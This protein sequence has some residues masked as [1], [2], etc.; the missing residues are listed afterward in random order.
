M[1]LGDFL[2]RQGL[3]TWL[4]GKTHFY[5]DLVGI[6]RLGIEPDSS[7]GKL[8]LQCGFQIFEHIEGLYPEG[9]KGRYN[10]LKSYYE[11]FLNE[12]GY[13]GQN[14]WNDWA[15]SAEGENGEVLEG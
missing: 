10:P 3:I 1:N 5:P 7:T 4:V 12:V 14:P 9:P 13:S 2:I 8:L 15:N 11:R 6:Q